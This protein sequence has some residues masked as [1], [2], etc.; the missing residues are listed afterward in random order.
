MGDVSASARSGDRRALP[1]A[2]EHRYRCFL[3]DLTGFTE[4]VTRAGPC[5]RS[6]ALKADGESTSIDPNVASA[7]SSAVVTATGST[8]TVE[9]AGADAPDREGSYHANLPE[10]PAG[11]I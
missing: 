3:P 10:P 1:L 5:D 7:A 4:S 8:S 9:L 11:L 2:I 6:S